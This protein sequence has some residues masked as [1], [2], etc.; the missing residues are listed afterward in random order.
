MKGQKLN[1]LSTFS[2]PSSTSLLKLTTV[3][4]TPGK[5]E[6]LFKSQRYY[7]ES[8][9]NSSCRPK[10]DAP[11]GSSLG[12]KSIHPM[13]ICRSLSRKNGTS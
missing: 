1:F 2:L 4:Y 6:R 11:E 10:F 8:E 12:L 13:C 3:C 5:D 7:I 9:G